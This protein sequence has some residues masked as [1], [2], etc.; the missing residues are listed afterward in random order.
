MSDIN[1]YGLTAARQHEARDDLKPGVTVIDLHGHLQIDA[2]HDIAGPH[3]DMSEQPFGQFS[4]SLS[5]QVG[6]QQERDRHEHLRSLEQRVADFDAMG[7]DLH[8]LLPVPLQSYYW[9]PPEVA[10]D[11][12]RAVNEG[13]AE[14]VKTDP[15]KF[16]GF[17]ATP[18][19]DTELAIAELD[20][21]VNKLGFKGVQVLTNVNGEELA[22]E[23]FEPFW[24]RA[25]Q[26]DC[27][28]FLHP[29][30]FSE[31]RR[32]S[33]HYFIN[34]IGNPFDTS[35]A[36]HHLIFEGV[37][38]RYPDLKLVLA[39][40]GGY[41]AAYSGRIDHAWGARE[42]CRQKTPNPPTSYL[43]KL[44]LDTVVFTPHQLKYLVDL[45]GADHIALGTDYPYDMA[46]YDPVGHVLETPELNAGQIESLLGGTARRLL[47]L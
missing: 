32:M 41:L 2:A 5:S 33:E 35:L 10:R 17:G 43:K 27:V 38:E 8:T 34:V 16:F 15:A 19:Q 12:C 11:A 6:Q 24:A 20:Y 4:S 21:C 14:A 1:P 13:I 22:S 36:V 30:G 9:V 47:K 39:H 31:G 37:L 29:N 26:L 28:V 23:R 42:D 25:E 40:G 3:V 46:E 18:M 45:F 44:Y 7:I